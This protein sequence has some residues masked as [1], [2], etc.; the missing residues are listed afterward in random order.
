MDV[1]IRRY[2]K[3]E[4]GFRLLGE[5]CGFVEDHKPP[6]SWKIQHSAEGP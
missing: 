2:P 4:I 1:L 3:L 5:T 6:E